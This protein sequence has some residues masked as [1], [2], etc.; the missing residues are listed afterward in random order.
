[1]KASEAKA[2]SIANANLAAANYRRLIDE[3]SRNKL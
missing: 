2:I 1:M 3:K